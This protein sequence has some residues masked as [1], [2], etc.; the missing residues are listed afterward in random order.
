MTSRVLVTGA[1]GLL[2]RPLSRYLAACGHKVLRHAFRAEGDLRGDLSKHAD[3][4]AVLEAATPDVIVNLVANTDVDYCEAH[5]EV[6]YTCNVRVVENLVGWILNTSDRCRLVQLS[7]DQVYDG[8]GP[9]T[10]SAALP[11]NYYAFSKY[12]GELAASRVSATVVRTNFFGP[13][14]TPGR[15]SFSDWIIASLRDKRKI[16]V[17]DDISFSPLTIRSLSSFIEMIVRN[18]IEGTF[19]VGSR[20]GST[21]A[22]FAFELATCLDLP[23]N[24][25]VRGSSTA[26][27]RAYRPRDMRMNSEHFEKVYHVQMPTLT[28]E[29]AAVTRAACEEARRDRH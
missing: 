28:S 23:T 25:M 29:I 1:A 10:E 2:G 22:D 16:N 15:V 12:A 20:V 24:A 19:N 7:T 27:V 13:S 9:H 17:F 26:T 6:A 21:K 11:R 5:P 4:R 8:P 18:P 14:E 3:V